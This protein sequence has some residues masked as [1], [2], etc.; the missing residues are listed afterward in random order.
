M[1]IFFQERFP[2]FL[3]QEEDANYSVLPCD[4]PHVLYTASWQYQSYGYQG[5]FKEPSLKA[6]PLLVLTKF[7]LLHLL[8]LLALA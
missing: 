4:L 7:S 2:S 6:F 5:D 1:A 8:R 3:Q